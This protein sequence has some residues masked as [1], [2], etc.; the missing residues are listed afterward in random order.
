MEVVDSQTCVYLYRARGSSEIRYVG[1]GASPERALQ[2][3]GGSHNAGLRALIETG[4]YVLEAAGPY[5]SPAV[6]ALVEAALISALS[7][8]GTQVALVNEAAGVGPKFR[9]LWAFRASWP[10]ALF[11]PR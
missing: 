4:E 2:H 9:P 10:P 8:S 11:S 5:A 6:G 1:K 7:R 3:M